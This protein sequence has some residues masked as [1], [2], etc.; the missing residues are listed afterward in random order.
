MT[1]GQFDKAS[2]L[3]AALHQD[4]GGIFP[5]QRAAHALGRI[6]M[7][8]FTP[9][10]VAKTISRAAHFA[11]AVPV[12]VRFSGDSGDP[13]LKPSAVIGMAMKFYLPDGTN[14]DLLA[15]NIPAFLGRTPEEFVGFLSAKAPD[16]KTGQPDMA[17]LGPFLASHPNIARV[18]QSLQSGA[19]PASLATASYRAMHA[20]RFVNAAGDGRWAR[21]HFE[22]AAGVVAQQAADLAKQPRDYLF[23]ELEGRL[24]RAPVAFRLDLEFAQAGDP[25][26]DPSAIWPAG[27]QRVNVG[28][29]ELTAPITETQIGNQSMLHDPTQVTDGIEISPTDQVVS[30]RRGSYL[31]SLAQRTGGWKRRS[32]V[33]AQAVLAEAGHRA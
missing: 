18:V 24:R 14:T 4:S 16:P 23:E 8:S 13:G 12:T 5:G 3:V 10:G 28:R 30:A 19:V 15:L 22:P 7:G 31:V 29:L 21:Y 33:L 17:K 2:E 27:R 26:D 6:F 32:S 11:A 1:Q 9:T 25:L 20:F